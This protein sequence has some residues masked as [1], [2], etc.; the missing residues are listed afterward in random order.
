MTTIGFIRHGCTDWNKEKR[1]QGQSDVPLNEMGRRQAQ[2]L[3]KRLVSGEWDVIVSSDLIRA[4]ETAEII[5]DHLKLPMLITDTRLRERAWGVLEGTTKQDRIQKWGKN[6]REL[7]AD[8]GEKDELILKRGLTAVD[9]FITE[10]NGKRILIVSHAGIARI[11]LKAMLKKPE[12]RP[13]KNTSLSIVQKKGQNW[14]LLL[15]NCTGHLS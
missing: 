14:N 7:H 4:K 3:A 1:K 11:L 6:W 8:A 10:H 2:A 15:Y 9:H 5:A 13:L 12:L